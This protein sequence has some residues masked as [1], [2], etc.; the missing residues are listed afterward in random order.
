MEMKLKWTLGTNNGITKAHILLY[1]KLTKNTMY[2]S[3]YASNLYCDFKQW[4]I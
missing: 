1:T 3:N 2:N 4:N